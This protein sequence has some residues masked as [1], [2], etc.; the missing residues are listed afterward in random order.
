[1]DFVLFLTL[2]T[3]SIYSQIAGP[4]H[5]SYESFIL[6]LSKSILLYQEEAFSSTSPTC[7]SSHT[8]SRK[9]GFVDQNRTARD[10]LYQRHDVLNKI[11]TSFKI[12]VSLSVKCSHRRSLTSRQRRVQSLV[13]H[14][15]V[16]HDS[17]KL[18]RRHVHGCQR[19]FSG[20][21]MI[22]ATTYTGT[23]RRFWHWP[24]HLDS[25]IVEA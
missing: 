15:H 25:N 24:L 8:S 7:S 1:M 18:V 21:N 5:P 3:P 14:R 4:S 11:P 20:A 12:M 9:D 19:S 13:S 6:S 2:S 17:Q 22:R 23:L 16:S 10:G